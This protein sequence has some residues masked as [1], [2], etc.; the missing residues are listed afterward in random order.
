MIRTLCYEHHVT[1]LKALPKSRRH[2]ASSWTTVAKEDCAECKR[3]AE[4]Q[5]ALAQEENRVREECLKIAIEALD[6]CAGNTLECVA[7]EALI[8]IEQRLAQL[9]PEEEIDNDN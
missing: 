5:P 7:D 2:E 3:L 4:L 6:W 9:E 8:Q 1:E